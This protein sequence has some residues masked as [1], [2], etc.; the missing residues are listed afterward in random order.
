[1]ITEKEYISYIQKSKNKNIS[2][3]QRFLNYEYD[4]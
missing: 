1:M 3:K 4:L 2:I